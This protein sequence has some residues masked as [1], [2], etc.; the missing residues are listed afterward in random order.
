MS[1]RANSGERQFKL[2]LRRS[3]QQRQLSCCA[4]SVPY[5]SDSHLY[6]HREH[7]QIA[8]RKAVEQCEH[9]LS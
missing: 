4:R 3:N 7:T 9:V 6:P 2:P 5:T 1:G 8:K